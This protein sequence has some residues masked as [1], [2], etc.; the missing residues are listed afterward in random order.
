MPDE[1]HLNLIRKAAAELIDHCESYLQT[2]KDEKRLDNCWAFG[3][4]MKWLA[5]R[6]MDVS[7]MCY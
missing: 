5:D 7:R 4:L 3:Q 1:F 2:L 6:L